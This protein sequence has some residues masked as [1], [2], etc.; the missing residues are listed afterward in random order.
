MTQRYNV[1]FLGLDYAGKTTMV[2]R[3]TRRAYNLPNKS[4]LSLEL[5]DLELNGLPLTIYDLPGQEVFQ[6]FLW[7]SV[8][9]SFKTNV[10]LFYI[11]VA[12][13]EQK[14][15]TEALDA[16]KDVLA[17]IE[18]NA[19]PY[20]L[21]VA[22]LANKI[23]TISEEQ[24]G[25]LITRLFLELN[26]NGIWDQ[27]ANLCSSYRVFWT[28]ALTGEGVEDVIDWITVNITGK[29]PP[30]KPHIKEVHL[31]EETGL[32]MV[33]WVDHTGR[34]LE[35]NENIFCGFVSAFQSFSNELHTGKIEIVET[36]NS[37]LAFL[38]KSFNKLSSYLVILSEKKAASHDLFTFGTQLHRE[39]S[40]RDIG[41][42]TRVPTLFKR[43]VEHTYSRT[44]EEG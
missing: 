1:Q 28:S 17:I 19:E 36:V 16:L 7:P 42:V 33:H 14:R 8:L 37:K 9:R 10:L 26:E 29:P 40:K 2:N 24:R 43:I 21:S 11:S 13:K 39:L 20:S 3:W 35:V 34:E 12:E 25:E 30:Q 41:S 4:T 31:I 23:D 22:V 38:H 5:H 27:L 15:W 18:K 6:D 32:P 44:F